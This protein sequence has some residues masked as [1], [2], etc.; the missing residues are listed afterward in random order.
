MNLRTILLLA[1]AIGQSCHA[2]L[3]ADAPPARPPVEDFF[4]NPEFSG[5]LLSPSGKYLAVKVGS[6]DQR[7]R[8]AVVE[9][10]ANTVK[11][12]GNFSDA[13]IG[14]FQWINDERLAFTA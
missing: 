2:V 1:C 7:D 5:A 10:G 4:G 13:D 3:A 14:K 11:V 9:L 12:V 6:K 8:L